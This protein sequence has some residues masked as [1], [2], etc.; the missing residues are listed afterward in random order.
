M[1]VV[2]NTLPEI[3]FLDK[4]PGVYEVSDDMYTNEEIDGNSYR[5][6]W[7]HA[8]VHD[9]A[10]DSLAPNITQSAN[11]LYYYENQTVYPDGEFP[12]QANGMLSSA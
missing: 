3:N 2:D 5:A 10:L 1:F 9:A 12:I 8:N 6:L 11:H 7:V 4:A